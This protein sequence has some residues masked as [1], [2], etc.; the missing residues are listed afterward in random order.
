MRS[1]F[2]YLNWVY[3]TL[4]HSYEFKIRL[5]IFKICSQNKHLKQFSLLLS[6][7]CNGS[8]SFCSELQKIY[9]LDTTWHSLGHLRRLNLWFI[10]FHSLIYFFFKFPWTFTSSHTAQ[11]NQNNPLG[12]FPEVHRSLESLKWKNNESPQTRKAF[13]SGHD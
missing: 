3:L 7:C 9:A 1:Y 5:L 10:L 12:T 2:Y 11:A 4:K 8:I 13:E 6:I